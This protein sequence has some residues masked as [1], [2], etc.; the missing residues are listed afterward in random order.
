MD[1]ET[2]KEHRAALAAQMAFYSAAN[3]VTLTMATQS[4]TAGQTANGL[5]WPFLGE[6]RN[7]E[8]I[9]TM[10]AYAAFVRANP[11]APPEAL[12]RFAAG[13][14][15]HAGAADGWTG[16][17][18]TWR[19]ACTVFCRTLPIYD[20]LV[21]AEIAVREA[22]AAAEKAAPAAAALS[23]PAEDTI[24]ERFGTILETSPNM[25]LQAVAGDQVDAGV[26]E[27][28]AA[29]DQ[30]EEQPLAGDQV[31]AGAGADEAPADDDQAEEQPVAGDQAE[32]AAEQPTA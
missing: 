22:S 6:E 28:P 8:I 31:D 18:F 4:L 17:D 9:D 30:A 1:L 14:E 24:L 16:I 23:L 26:G 27:A 7:A 19:A 15:F 12:Y 10:I 5:T 32:Q 21:A 13:R 20:E 29:D 2:L 11:T 25:A 3:V